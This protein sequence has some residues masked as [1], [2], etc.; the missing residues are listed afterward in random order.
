MEFV[1]V[2]PAGA[3]VQATPPERLP[4]EGFVWCDCVPDEGRSWVEPMRALTGVAIFEDHL[5]DAENPNHPSYFD[6]TRH[7]EMIVF[8]GLATA[9]PE[10]NGSM[11]TI[12]IRTRPTVFYLMPG[13][14]VVVHPA[15]SRQ[16]PL[17]RERL[18]SAADSH[19]RLPSCPEE[20]MLRILNGMVDKYL[21]LRQPLT[22]Q[23]EHW[24]H[25]L[26]NPRKP[27]HDWMLLL[28]ARAEARKLEQLC[29]EQ[30]DALQEW[31]DERVEHFGA[32][33][34]PAPTAP[35]ALPALSD[36][37]QV[38]ANDLVEHIHRV[39]NHARR[40][41]SSVES[42]V[43][44]HFSATAYR[45]NEIMRTLTTITA[46]FMPLTLITGIFGMNFD[47][48][49]GLHWHAGF[50]VTIAGMALIT[51]LLMAF[52]RAKRYF[53]SSDYRAAARRRKLRAE[54]RKAAARG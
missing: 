3:T 12:R 22:E 29:E 9:P 24:Q 15:D 35:T 39:L 51:V 49:P 16:V 45:T 28:D 10:D 13:A 44:L 21:D 38:R 23:L 11:E 36:S 42:A 37:L 50:W 26:L 1:V 52:F 5:L 46:I 25:L 2:T 43:Q 7:Y 31:R 8:R 17:I 19:Q 18:R 54:A 40:L 32:G 20:L 14:L 6:S 30:L 27:F 33:V 47:A 41:E 4:D 34:A 53:E 48:I